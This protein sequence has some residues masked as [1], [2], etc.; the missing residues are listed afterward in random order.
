MIVIRTA[1]EMARAL[2][3]ALDPALLRRL[4]THRDR[5]SEWS[6]YELGELAVFVIVQEGDTVEQAEA[7]YGQTLVRDET[8]TLL[9]EL[10]ER[11][12]GIMEAT[13]ILSQDGFGLKLLVQVG[14]M[15]DARLIA[16]CR[17]ASAQI[18]SNTNC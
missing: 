14:P 5:L 1:E 10:I 7:A 16:A 6:D 3:S 4:Q 12:G 9:P 18:D 15:A 17:N 2:H 11:H 8:F 13:F